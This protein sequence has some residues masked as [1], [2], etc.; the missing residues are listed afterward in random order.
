V[1]L[2]VINAGAAIYAAGAADSIADGVQAARAAVADGSAAE[3]LE[4]YVRA[5]NAGAD[6]KAPL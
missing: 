1:E 6:A 4:N 5:S 3:A 2:A